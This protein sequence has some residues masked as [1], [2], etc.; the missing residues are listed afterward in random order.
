MACVVPRDNVVTLDGIA[1]YNDPLPRSYGKSVKSRVMG[2]TMNGP[3]VR[4]CPYSGAG[5]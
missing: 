2:Q 4:V 1:A 5:L 3:I